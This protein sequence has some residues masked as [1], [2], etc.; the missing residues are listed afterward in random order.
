MKKNNKAYEDVFDTLD[1]Y[2]EEEGD[3]LLAKN[4]EDA[5]ATYEFY[6]ELETKE[7]E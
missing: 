3:K 4:K 7:G 6:K 2:Y 5:E 1:D